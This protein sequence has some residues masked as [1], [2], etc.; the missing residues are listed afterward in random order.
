VYEEKSV[1]RRTALP[2]VAV[3]ATFFLPMTDSCKD[4]V[5][6]LTYVEGG[7][8]GP[9][10]WVI[11]T[12]VTAAVLAVAVFRSWRR[13]AKTALA[14]A[15][16]GA[17]ALTLPALA[18]MFGVDGAY[19][20]AP[21]Y[22]VAT[23]ATALLMKRAREKM[24]WQRLSALLDAYAAAAFPLAITIASLAKY[25]GAYVF[26]IAYVAFATQRALVALQSIGARRAEHRVRIAAEEPR[27]RIGEREE[28]EALEAD[29]LE[30][31][32]KRLVSAPA[33]SD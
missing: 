14:F 22:A 33:S 23:L 17:F 27:A 19:V 4:A 9:V 28:E 3:V 13:K 7:G 21:I 16:M 8:V 6:P 15:T 30:E 29:V 25:S 18:V 11:P 32:A 1:T 26:V 20:M 31:N 2:L 10:I 5:S 24:G 12:F